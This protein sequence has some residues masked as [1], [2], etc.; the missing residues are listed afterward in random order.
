MSAHL[1]AFPN[2]QTGRELPSPP[3][4]QFVSRQDYSKFVKWGLFFQEAGLTVLLERRGQ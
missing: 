4:M 3:V 1:L 2:A